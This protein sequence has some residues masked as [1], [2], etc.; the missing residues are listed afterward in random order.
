MSWNELERLE[1]RGPRAN[2]WR[3]GRS[4]A[5][6]RHGMVAS[7][8]SLATL[9]GVDCLRRGGT[10]MDAAIATA[11][12]L[13]VVEPMMT[14]IG[15]DAFFLYYDASTRRVDGFNGSGRSPSR[16]PRSHFGSGAGGGI[17]RDSWGAV[18]VPG[19]VSAWWEGWRRHGRLP[20]SDLLAPAI[21]Y[22]EDGFP[23]TEIVHTVWRACEEGLRRDPEGRETYLAR[24]RAPA[25]GATFRIPRLA[26]SL[27]AVAA[28]G[29][30]AFYRGPIAMEIARYARATGGF[31]EVDDFA[32]HQG[33][34]VE[35]IST[36]YRGYE[37]LQIPPNGQGIGALLMLDLLSGY[38]LAALGHS[39][40][41]C[42]HLMIEAKKVAFADLHRHVCDP[43][44]HAV[45]VAELLSPDHAARRREAIDR[46][47]AAT[48]VEPAAIASSGTSADPL[49]GKDD[50][51]IAGDTVYLTAIDGHGN[52]ASF[53]N[54]LYDAFGTR[55]V[56]GRT[57]ILLHSR[58][59][60]FVLDRGHPN[61]YAPGK[62]PFH[63]IIPGMVRRDGRLHLSYG[64]MGGAFQPQGHVQL[65]TGLIDF[66][67]TP[68][69]A[70][71]APRWRHVDGLRVL[72]E[73]GTPR[74]TCDALAGR[75]HQVEPAS[76]FAFG[77][78]QAI[79][80]DPAT[81]TFVGASDPRKDGCALGY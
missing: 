28:G 13:G 7:S 67:L 76:G 65:L 52:A 51:A 19:A 54:S 5:M 25:L 2:P 23:V 40:P 78:A 30:D 55:I 33:A 34:W 56:G 4:H 37:V 12:V 18:T 29:A 73:H 27:R 35:P 71:D 41:E 31:L 66:G 75:G 64:V 72:L 50:A 77:G 17:A 46:L 81:G 8:H 74:A 21:G 60:G 45:P 57:G 14:G 22:A 36:T 58:G 3:A 49:R 63:T 80:V 70:I 79:L 53:I 47:R 48:P 44:H 15:G 11:A 10:A 42:L 24:E 68:Q 32:R 20:F 61:E 59:A 62:R 1:Q 26:E 43:E 16:L 39:T 9:A 69:E 38:D 6:S